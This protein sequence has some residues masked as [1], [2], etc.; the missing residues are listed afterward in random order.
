MKQLKYVLLSLALMAP[1][2]LVAQSANTTDSQQEARPMRRHIPDVDTQLQ[3]LS[4]KLKLTDEQKPQVKTILEDQRD[5]MQKLMQEPSGA[6]GEK[7]QKMRE[8]H[9]NAS[10]KIR[11]LLTDEQKSKYDK[12]EAQRQERMQKRRGRRGGSA[13]GQ[14]D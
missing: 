14:Q 11:T 9:E 4:K 5:Q 8:I 13:P 12:L 6:Q 3:R 7:R 10:S 1:A 2:G